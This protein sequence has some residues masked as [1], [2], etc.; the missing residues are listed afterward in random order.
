[1]SS[2]LKPYITHARPARSR[3]ADFGAVARKAAQGAVELQVR[4]PFDPEQASLSALT[5][6]RRRTQER[7]GRPPAESRAGTR[8]GVEVSRTPRPAAAE[9][10]LEDLD[11]LRRARHGQEPI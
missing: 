4:K 9:R 2:Q 3:F 8:S 1:M 5:A 11:Q 6:A 7:P 10:A